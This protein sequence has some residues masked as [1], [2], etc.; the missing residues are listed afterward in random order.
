[1]EII[2]INYLVDKGHWKI[3]FGI[4]TIEIMKVRTDAH[5]ALFFVNK[6]GF[7]GYHFGWV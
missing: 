1:M 7:D 4:G 3:V 6:D 5:S 2:I